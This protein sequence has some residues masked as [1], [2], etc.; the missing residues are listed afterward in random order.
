[1]FTG[2]IAGWI[3]LSAAKFFNKFSI[4][5][6]LFSGWIE[7]VAKRE[8][9]AEFLE[10]IKARKKDVSVGEMKTAE[11]KDKEVDDVDEEGNPIKR[12]ET[13]TVEGPKRSGADLVGSIND[14]A[15]MSTGV[16]CGV[17]TIAATLTGIKAAI[18]VQN[19][20]NFAQAGNEAVQKTKF[21]D[22]T[23]S[24][25]NTYANMLTTRDEEGNYPLLAQ[26]LLYVVSGGTHK[27]DM[28]AATMSANV[29]EL[30][31]SL[32]TSIGAVIG[33][34]IAQGV[35]AAISFVTGVLTFGTFSVGKALLGMLSGL[36]VM[37]VVS[38]VVERIAAGITS[39][40]CVGET[41]GLE[42]GTNGSL[43]MGACL[44]TGMSAEL[45]KNA[46]LGGSS[47]GDAGMVE[48]NEN[49]RAIALAYEAEYD[50]A[51]YSP[52]DVTNK[53]TFFGSL[54]RTVA[55]SLS[56][57]A[58]NGSL[59][60][61]ASGM[62]TMAASSFSALVPGANAAIVAENKMGDCPG[63]QSVGMQGYAD[64]SCNPIAVNDMGTMGY[65][66]EEN[67][68]EIAETYNGF[69]KDGDTVKVSGGVEQIDEESNLGKYINY[70]V[71]RESPFGMVD[72]TILDKEASLTGNDTADTVIGVLPII[73]D[74][75]DAIVSAL[76]LGSDALGWATGAT[77]GAKS[78]SNASA[79]TVSVSTTS[80]VDNDA[81]LAPSYPVNI[82]PWDEIKH[83]AQYVTDDKIM[84]TADPENY[85]SA[86]MA[87]IEKQEEKN[88]VDNSF[89][90]WL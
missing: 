9:D 64:G 26:G 45:S 23:E 16:F 38:A 80:S 19:A 35:T 29:E 2:R 12:T 27:V 55:T 18:T 62:S 73:G 86:V 10:T 60:S 83:Y 69:E 53:N 84:E 54:A 42:D 11:R 4:S 77:C 24:P 5:K 37:G 6:T 28:D 8:G 61:L 59:M 74:A 65:D 68:V 17:A 34:T 3:D 70:C 44:A 85:N 56:T 48:K 15:Q 87:Y 30:Y 32:G 72:Q 20:I 31:K 7:S 52:F 76:K 51:N 14:I 50:R 66:P 89:E 71:D 79:S 75:T 63:L 13:E 36:A 57:F 25:T 78:G 39:D 1:S 88:P 67:L 58:G 21:G 41:E 49:A 81:G 40:Q 22:G 33:C 46:L 82:V 47:P 90:G 43:A